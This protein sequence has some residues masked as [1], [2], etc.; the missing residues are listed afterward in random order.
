MDSLAVIA[1]DFSGCT[2]AELQLFPFALRT[3]SLL[4]WADLPSFRG[5]YHVQVVDNEARSAEPDAAYRVTRALVER[6]RR[7]GAE[8]L[9]KKV[10]STFRGNIG[11]ELDAAMDALEVDSS[12]LVPAY[13]ANGRVTRDGYHY[14]HGRLLA[15]TD[16]ARD[17]VHP[18]T[19]SY[20]PRLLQR[21]T[22]RQVGSV[23]LEAV[24]GGP[25]SLVSALHHKHLSGDRILVVDAE[26]D[27]DMTTIAEALKLGD[28]LRLA[29]GSASMLGPIMRAMGAAFGPRPEPEPLDAPVLV[30]NGS[31]HPLSAKQIGLLASRHGT[32]IVGL[33]TRDLLDA[34]AASG[35]C[36]RVVREAAEALAA[37]G[38]A[39][40]TTHL[41]RI[42]DRD[43]AAVGETLSRHLGGMV[44]RLVER[45]SARNLYI[46][47]G[48]TSLAVFSALGIQGVSVLWKV[49]P[50]IA[51]CRTVGGKSDLRTT[52]KPGGFGSESAV[53]AGVRLMTKGLAGC[54]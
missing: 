32:K 41:D 38:Q 22:K 53:M 3:V 17:P 28:R 33:R 43:P 45:H 54:P 34:S 16:F 9:F 20:L 2:D 51:L 35:Q 52:I 26:T 48:W 42:S 46:I 39:V 27:G 30:V 14:V 8:R 1:D 47:G 31:L 29:A 25:E 6:L 37:E 50:G 11:P 19:D 5:G 7:T 18:M 36:E 21:Q 10:D 24:R 40:L 12:V 49:E 13:P 4:P 44:R 23:S 15:E